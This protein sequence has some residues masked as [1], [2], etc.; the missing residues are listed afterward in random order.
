MLINNI[1]ILYIHTN[2]RL[3]DHAPTLHTIQEISMSAK[4]STTVMSP[5]AFANAVTEI[6]KKAGHDKTIRP[7][8]MYNYK[9]NNLLKKPLT[10][11]YATEWAERYIA[12]NLS[13]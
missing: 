5:Y 11:E 3:R 9:K 8:M 1:L 6:I 13:K 12:R 10:A 2:I 7:Q 4:P